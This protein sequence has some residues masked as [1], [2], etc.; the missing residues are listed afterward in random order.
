[1]K[2]LELTENL[3]KYT[4]IDECPVRNVLAHFSGKWALLLL[5]VLSENESTRFNIIQ[6][7]I[8]DVSSKVLSDT[9]KN[10]EKDNLISRKVYA[11][12]PPRVEYALTPLGRSLIPVIGRLIN[13]ALE[14]FDKFNYVKN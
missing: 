10:L 2:A 9:L 4:K 13:W 1:M 5:C 3:K 6:K 7:A 11:E 8:P 12:I 14:N